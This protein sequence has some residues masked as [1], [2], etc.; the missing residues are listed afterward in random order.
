MDEKIEQL[1]DNITDGDPV[2]LLA[3]TVVGIAFNSLA[4][5]FRLQELRK[6]V[7]EIDFR[8]DHRD[9]IAPQSRSM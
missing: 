3:V 8:S 5:T 7:D 6:Q 4:Q 2:T 9:Q 1:V